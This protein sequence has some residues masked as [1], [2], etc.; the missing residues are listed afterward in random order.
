MSGTLILINLAGGVA[1]LLW[2]LHMVH[3]GVVRAF[4]AQLRRVLAVGLADRFRALLAGFGVTMALQSSTAAAMMT[5]AFTADGIV[6]LLPALAIML[7]ANIGTTVIVQVFSFDLTWLSPLLVLAGVVA[8]KR[9]GRTRT[10][11]LGRVSIGLGLMLLA[12]H[13]LV[14]A[15]E[16]VEASP[17]LRGMF[18]AL[19]GEPLLGVLLAAVLTWAAHSS[20]AVVLLVMSLAVAGVL[21]PVTAL[22]L[23]LGANL[24]GAVPPLL[25]SLG[26]DPAA[27]RLPA[28]NLAF[29]AL[30]CVLAL[31]FLDQISAVLAAVGPEV[32]RQAVN[33]HTGFNLVLAVLFLPLLGPAA[34]LLARAFPEQAKP[35]DPGM[36]QHLDPAA[37][38]TPYVALANAAREV[39]RMADVLEA[40]L[41]GSLDAFRTGDR[42][43]VAEIGQMDNVLD[44]L[45]AAIKLYLAELSAGALD[46]QDSR[47][48]SDILALAINLEQAGDL[49]DKGL[50]ALASK[51]IK[52]RLSFS[53]EGLAEIHTLH[54]RL[55]ENLQVAVAVFMSDDPRSARRL[56]RE[57][58]LF[59]DLER[60]A[61]ESHFDRLRDGRS[62]SVET[63][64]LHLD[65]LRD[66]KRINSHLVTAAYPIL[67]Q[68]GELR[69]SRL[70]DA[71]R[72][73]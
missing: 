17:L 32:A 31:P 26:P 8:F 13:L 12:L 52:R 49:V 58:E 20:A 48:C 24:G 33:F 3:S 64:A 60:A 35:S 72:A 4:G 50:M 2:G 51:Q 56:V 67:D 15:M 45:N 9:G 66:L 16:P 23:V 21:A 7:G 34:R 5:A 70:V 68:T 30:G 28:G 38:E 55:I 53:D 65:I 57:K 22:A 73:S 42:K 69:R 47:R 29:R 46:E 18:A 1:L 27:R 14:M 25:A 44:R 63:S 39:L 54:E 40:M 62:E 10:R 37:L 11:D 61:T 6:H 43:R 59:R 41:R 36:P 19:D 71:V